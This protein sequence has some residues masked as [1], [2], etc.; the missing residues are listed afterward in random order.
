MELYKY[1]LR[2]DYPW[3]EEKGP[4]ITIQAYKCKKEN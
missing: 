4:N 3:A 2:Y 1:N